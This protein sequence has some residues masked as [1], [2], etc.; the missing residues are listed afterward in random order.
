MIS[1]NS[2]KEQM[3]V[4]LCYRKEHIALQIHD[5][6]R[7][8]LIIIIMYGADSSCRHRQQPISIACIP[9]LTRPGNDHYPTKPGSESRASITA[10]GAPN[11]KIHHRSGCNVRKL[12][13]EKVDASK[14]VDPS[15]PYACASATVPSTWTHPYPAPLT[16]MMMSSVASVTNTPERTQLR[17]A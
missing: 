15:S 13:V 3:V 12:S 11:K 8:K 4:L 6:H 7:A 1:Q 14:V 9:G 5:T 10:L 16:M 17:G 2:H